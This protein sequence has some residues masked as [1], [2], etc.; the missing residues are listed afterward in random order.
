MGSV[1][2]VGGLTRGRR[3]DDTTSLAWLLSTP[4]CGEVSRAIHEVAGLSRDASNIHKTA[5]QPT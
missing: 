1:K 3:F 5:P 2:S 4:A